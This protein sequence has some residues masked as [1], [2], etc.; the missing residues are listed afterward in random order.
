M[1]ANNIYKM[2]NAGGFKSLN[3]YQDMLAGNPAV[4]FN[5]YESIATVTVGSGGQSTISFTGIPST[6][7][8]LQIRAIA[9]GTRSD[10]ADGLTLQFN[11]DTGSNY[12]YHYLY[13]N[14][15][16]ASAGSWN[17]TRIPLESIMAAATS[18]SG[19]FGTMVTDILDYADTNKFKTVRNLGGNDR[20]GSGDVVFQSGN[21][22]NTNAITSIEIAPLYG[23][24]FAQYSQFALYG[25]KG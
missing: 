6:F 20:N 10:A 22:R 23:A 18:G 15:S 11:S 24:G 2:S 5:S 3:R 25:I 21:W 12:S 14:G 4:L 7:K 17:Q 9:R 8:H 1:A 19:I 16:A 13:G